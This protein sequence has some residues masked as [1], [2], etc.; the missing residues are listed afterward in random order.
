MRQ[1]RRTGSSIAHTHTHT[2]LQEAE[3]EGWDDGWVGEAR[4]GAAASELRERE[5]REQLINPL[6]AGSLR[7]SQLDFHHL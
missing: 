7:L 3:S 2:E 5:R 4:R 6:T 1:D